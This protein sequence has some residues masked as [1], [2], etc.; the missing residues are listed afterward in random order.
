MELYNIINLPKEPFIP[1][2]K[3]I[4]RNQEETEILVSEG[5]YQPPVI[6][7]NS[8]IW[9][10]DLIESAEKAGISKL[11][12]HLV[13]ENP[14]E[15]LLAALRLQNRKNNFSF[16]EKSAVLAYIRKNHLEDHI[17][18]ISAEIQDEGDFTI[19]TDKYDTLPETVKDGID[20][21]LIDIKTAVLMKD[22]PAEVFD[23]IFRC[24]KISYSSRRIILKEILEISR[25]DGLTQD[26]CIRLTR[27]IADADNPGESAAKI[28]YP[29]MES[30]KEAFSNYVSSTVKGS[31]ITLEAPQGFEGSGFTARFQIKSVTQLERIIRTLEKVKESADQLFKLL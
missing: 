8:I 7:E 18:M 22:L 20:E 26:E 25:R 1:F 23:I 16:S 13:A 12:C 21:N 19:Y 10:N 14:L 17:S 4:S 6:T 29:K 27:D 9:G 30:M 3:Y 24:G 5:Y 31:G 28:R 15:N 11:W 2:R